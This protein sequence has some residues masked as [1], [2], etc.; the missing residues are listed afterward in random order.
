MPNYSIKRYALIGFNSLH[1]ADEHVA[2]IT[3]YLPSNYRVEGITSL[4][5]VIGGYDRYGW[6]LDRYVLPRLGSGM[7]G[8]VEVDLSHD[9]MKELDAFE[10]EEQRRAKG[11]PPRNVLVDDCTEF[12]AIAGPLFCPGDKNEWYLY[13]DA[14]RVE[15][16]DNEADRGD[17]RDDRLDRRLFLHCPV[18]GV[19]KPTKLE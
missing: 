16:E 19:T 12:T 4:G 6:T 3:R 7:Y 10:R 13:A 14:R 18:T 15:Q 1:T 11:L 9:C 5:I 8:G 17:H 2:V